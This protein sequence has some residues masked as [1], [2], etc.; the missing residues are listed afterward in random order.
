MGNCRS[1]EYS[2]SSLSHLPSSSSSSSSPSS[3]PVKLH[4]GS[5]LGLCSYQDYSNNNYN[6]NN[7]ISSNSN[8]NGNRGIDIDR[9]IEVVTCSD[10]KRVSKFTYSQE[11]I[12]GTVRYSSNVHSKA[13]NRV[14]ASRRFIWS[15]SRDLTVAQV[16]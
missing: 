8:S 4:E 9:G 13:I 11:S 5:I 10:D 3:I 7:N 2:P 16:I 15:T 14:A 6:N 12:S 1:H